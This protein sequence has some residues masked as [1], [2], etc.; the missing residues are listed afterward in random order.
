[1]LTVSNCDR[2]YVFEPYKQLV[3]T[4]NLFSIRR[5][6]SHNNYNQTS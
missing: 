4:T 2:E 3:F 6:V 1:M 5:I